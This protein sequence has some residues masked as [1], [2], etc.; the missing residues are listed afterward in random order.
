MGSKSTWNA[1][2]S[3]SGLG[4]PAARG[5]YACLDS[6]MR[7]EFLWFNLAVVGAYLS[8]RNVFLSMLADTKHMLDNAVSR[9]ILV[10][11][12]VNKNLL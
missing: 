1:N 8:G 3:G 6:A 4:L 7:V 5:G 9:A 11:D 2:D 10:K 12:F